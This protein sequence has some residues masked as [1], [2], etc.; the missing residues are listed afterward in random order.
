MITRRSDEW[1]SGTAELGGIHYSFYLEHLP[2]NESADISSLQNYDC[3]LIQLFTLGKSI[4]RT[5]LGLEIRHCNLQTPDQAP[6]H[7]TESPAHKF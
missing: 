6:H 7:E 2:Y 3:R 4:A 5:H 1:L